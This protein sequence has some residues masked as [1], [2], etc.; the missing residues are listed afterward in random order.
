MHHIASSLLPSG[1]VNILD[2]NS[3]S[4]TK[5]IRFIVFPCFLDMYIYFLISSFYLTCLVLHVVFTLI[6]IFSELNLI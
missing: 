4:M 3:L 1:L 5:V 6:I 2:P